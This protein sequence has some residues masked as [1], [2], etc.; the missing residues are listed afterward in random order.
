MAYEQTQS[1]T[2]GAVGFNR[3]AHKIHE[4]FSNRVHMA[5]REVFVFFVYFAVH[6]IRVHPWLENLGFFA[7][8][9]RPSRTANCL[10]QNAMGQFHTVVKSIRTMSYAIT[11][12]P[13]CP[14]NSR[15]V[16]GQIHAKTP[17]RI[18]QK[19]S[20][21]APIRAIR[22]ICPFRHVATR[23]PSISVF[24]RAYPWLK[25]LGFFAAFAAFARPVSRAKKKETKSRFMIFKVSKRLFAIPKNPENSTLHNNVCNNYIRETYTLVCS[26]GSA[27][28][29]RI[30]LS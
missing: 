12:E 29:S 19:Q 11:R 22:P 9:A 14:K 15:L 16:G 13:N 25:N 8:F 20:I 28:M 18:S 6:L 30:F 27:G 2:A 10:R 3:E 5:A 1:D 26:T 23:I 7:A 24:I 4:M 17:R 21:F